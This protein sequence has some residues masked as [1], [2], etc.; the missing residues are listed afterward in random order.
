VAERLQHHVFVGGHRWDG[1]E[2]HA[3]LD[4]WL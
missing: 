2:A 4:R 3:W 1:A